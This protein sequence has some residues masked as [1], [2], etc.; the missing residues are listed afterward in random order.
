MLCAGNTQNETILCLQGKSENTNDIIST[1]FPANLRRTVWQLMNNTQTK[2][3]NTE[4]TVQPTV[5]SA[6]TWPQLRTFFSAWWKH[7]FVL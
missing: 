6:S 1:V 4:H 2:Q 7:F 3:H 5:S